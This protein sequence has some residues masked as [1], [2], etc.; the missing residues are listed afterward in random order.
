MEMMVNM[1]R[2][3]YWSARTIGI[4][5]TAVILLTA[6]AAFAGRR[7]AIAPPGIGPSAAHVNGVPI[8]KVDVDAKATMIGSK[9]SPAPS[10]E[11]VRF[12]VLQNMVKQEIL[13]QTA[14]KYDIRISDAEV[15]AALSETVQNI[16]SPEMDEVSRQESLGYIRRMGLT[17]DQYPTDPRVINSWRRTY[18][19]DKMRQWVMDRVP[20]EKRTS[21][22]ALEA[23]VD[24]FIELQHAIV[25]YP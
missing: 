25:T 3:R 10:I 8:Y 5:V 22:Q 15:T 17:L 19:I 1:W 11:D 18:L 13:Y 6:G 24:D 20:L 14:P 4:I 16:L 7:R 12:S 23:A 9:L 2:H 21:P